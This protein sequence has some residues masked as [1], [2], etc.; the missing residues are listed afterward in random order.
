MSKKNILKK[1][2]FLLIPAILI[3]TAISCKNREKS[4]IEVINEG[5]IQIEKDIAFFKGDTFILRLDAYKPGV[6]KEKKLKPIVWLHG[7]EFLPFVDKEQDYIVRFCKYFAEKGYF[8][9]AP[10]YR[11]YEDPFA[12]WEQTVSNSIDDT[13][14]AIEWVKKNKNK[15]SLDLNHLIIAGGSSGGMISIWAAAEYSSTQQTPAVFANI[16]LWG[17]PFGQV[18]HLTR[19][20]PPALIVH[21]TDDQSVPYK[22]SIT[23][24][25]KLNDLGVYNELMTIEGEGHTPVSHFDEIALR[26]E[27]FLKKPEQQK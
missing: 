3:S 24:S 6:K 1:A 9:I 23:L 26:I 18:N 7:G 8:C 25:E 13:F 10:D 14:R 20:F 5:N 27:A 15:Y 4:K 12:D 22:N 11:T 16:D 19:D 21:G 17:S 2:I